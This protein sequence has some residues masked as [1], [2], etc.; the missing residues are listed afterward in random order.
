MKKYLSFLRLISLAICPVLLIFCSGQSIA[1]QSRSKVKKVVFGEDSRAAAKIRGKIIGSLPGNPRV[2]GFLIRANSQVSRELQALIAPNYQVPVNKGKFSIPFA[3]SGLYMVGVF[4]DKIKNGLLD[5]YDDPYWFAQNMPVRLSSSKIFEFNVS[6]E[7]KTWPIIS[8]KNF[9]ENHSL[10]FQISS[11]QGSPFMLLPIESNP[12]ELSGITKPFGFSVIIDRNENEIVDPAEQTRNVFW[13][14]KNPQTKFEVEFG[15]VWN[16]LTI[17]LPNGNAGLELRIQNN[18]ADQKSN[19]SIKIPS[20]NRS[21]RSIKLAHL[22]LGEYQLFLKPKGSTEEIKGPYFVQERESSWEIELS[23]DYFAKLKFPL[24][25]D[26]ENSRL[27]FFMSG[28]PI[29]NCKPNKTVKL[30]QSGQYEVAWYSD[31]N[32]VKGLN[33]DKILDKIHATAK[34]ELKSNSQTTTVNLSNTARNIK[35]TGTYN[36]MHTPASEV[37]LHFFQDTDLKG[38]W[39]NI[40]SHKT[41]GSESATLPIEI[42]IDS[43]RNLYIYLD[44]AG[45]AK[46][47]EV[48]P[49]YIQ[50]IN[51]QAL[52]TEDNEFQL[53]VISSGTLNLNIAGSN[54][55]KYFLEIARVD[56][57]EIIAASFLDGGKNTFEN[58]PLGYP[59]NLNIIHD[60]NAN[61]EL[62]SQDKV[63]PPIPISIH[64]FEQ[65][66]S[67]PINLENL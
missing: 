1:N 12:F 32:T 57:E 52:R 6:V 53:P 15:K 60:I 27:Q 17:D 49:E 51:P 20:P 11:I 18:S 42:S 41:T 3:Q 22:D 5:L 10:L 14:P 13:V 7:N 36:W 25:S 34:F 31:T 2:Y 55:E 65:K 35:I 24:K 61:Q 46:L 48:K 44:L 21:E 23:E 66:L 67:L 4:A 63:L 56:T 28:T 33:P 50:V 43:N 16:P 47:N 62:D 38:Y 29:Y 19:N 26:T 39:N 8:L 54:P 9:P 59:L 58:L 40:F 37:H 64:L 30:Y 45:D